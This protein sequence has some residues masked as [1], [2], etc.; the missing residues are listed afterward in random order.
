[1]LYWKLLNVF[2]SSFCLCCISYT[3]HTL[4]RSV[5]LNLLI[6]RNQISNRSLHFTDLFLY[7]FSSTLDLYCWTCVSDCYFVI[8]LAINS[9]F[10]RCL[11]PFVTMY[12]SINN[13][14]IITFIILNTLQ[15]HDYISYTNLKT[16]IYIISL[17]TYAELFWEISL[18]LHWLYL[19]MP[20]PEAQQKCN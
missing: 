15:F 3:T 1:M 17:C 5:N 19:H 2:C 13:V 16:I 18:Y 8:W 10:N 14:I 4:L 12:V 6:R 9:V 11:E 7:C 20:H